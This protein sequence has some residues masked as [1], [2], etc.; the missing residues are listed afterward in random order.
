[1]R[2]WLASRTYRENLSPQGFA[3]EFLRRNPDYKKD[4]ADWNAERANDEESVH[5][6]ITEKWALLIGPRD[7]NVQGTPTTEHFFDVPGLAGRVAVAS[8]E[9]GRSMTS[10]NFDLSAPLEPQIKAAEKFLRERQEWLVESEG[11]TARVKS[12]KYKMPDLV[13]YLKILDL[14]TIG[15]TNDDI[16]A[17]C[18]PFAS[19]SH[20]EFS[21][22]Q[23]AAKAKQVATYIRDGGYRDVA[24]MRFSTK[25][26]KD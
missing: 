26:R 11:L 16:A 19:N 8:R 3:W 9:L 2:A 18:W 17:I 12:T 21:G 6:P 7:P 10:T 1:M 13:K 14:I 5:S 25:Q 23:R 15:A 22:R 4:Y 20:P 24:L